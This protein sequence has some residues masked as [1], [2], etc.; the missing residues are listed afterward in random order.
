MTVLAVDFS[1]VFG[2]VGRVKKL[3][4]K[5][6]LETGF[7]PFLSTGEPFLSSVHGLAT[8][9]AFWVLWRL[10]RHSEEF[11]LPYGEDPKVEFR[12]FNFT[13]TN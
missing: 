12:K 8:F 4:A 1:F 2:A 13:Y 3:V 9:G 6:A 10:E 11:R 5:T 7:V